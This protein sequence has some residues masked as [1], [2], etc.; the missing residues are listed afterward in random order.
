MKKIIFLVGTANGGKST[1]LNGLK[2]HKNQHILDINGCKVYV[3]NMSNCDECFEKYLKKIKKILQKYDVLIVSLCI[4]EEKHK[5]GKLFD[6]IC[7]RINQ[8]E[9]EKYFFVIKNG[10]NK[11]VDIQKLDCFTKHDITLCDN[12]SAG[13]IDEFLDYLNSLCMCDQCKEKK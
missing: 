8:L 7:N 3:K 12:Q 5:C 1:T 11:S 6:E 9:A 13:C 4:D 2:E 10:K